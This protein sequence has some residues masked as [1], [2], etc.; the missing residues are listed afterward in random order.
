MAYSDLVLTL[1]RR[2]ILQ[3][4]DVATA[5]G[6]TIDFRDTRLGAAPEDNA[7]LRMIYNHLLAV[8][9]KQAQIDTLKD[10]LPSAPA[11]KPPDS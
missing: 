5:I 3:I 10:Q 6:N 4:S 9:Q 7:N 1:H 2:G 8:E 11:S